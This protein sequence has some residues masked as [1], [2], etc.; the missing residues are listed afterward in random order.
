MTARPETTDV[1]VIGGGD[2]GSD[3]VGTAVRQ[4][5]LS[6]NNFELLEKPPRGRP[7]H[8]PW[9][10]YPM[11]LRTS[12]SHEEGATRSWSILTKSFFGEDGQVKGLETGEVMWSGN[13]S[14]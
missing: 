13:L 9:P 11:R 12:T 14:L 4:G 6:V 7:A 3:C 5:A 1:I 10:Y 8:Q 2:T